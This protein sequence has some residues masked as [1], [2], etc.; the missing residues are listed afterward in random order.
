MVEEARIA[1]RMGLLDNS[2]LESLRFVLTLYG[3]PTEIPDEVDIIHLNKIM[4]QDKKVR[5]GRLTIPILVGL[6]KTE[7]KIVDVDS[8]LNLIKRNGVESKC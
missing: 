1:V 8:N 2:V 4:Q 3:L 6:G 5:H 7:M